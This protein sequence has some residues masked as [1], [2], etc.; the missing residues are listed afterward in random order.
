MMDK[1]GLATG[2]TD[3]GFH[4]LFNVVAGNEIETENGEIKQE[5]MKLYFLIGN[6]I[7]PFGTPSRVTAENLYYMVHALWP[8][9]I[10]DVRGFDF[11]LDN[12]EK[13]LN[14]DKDDVLFKPRNKLTPSSGLLNFVLYQEYRL[15]SKE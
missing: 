6:K 4:Y 2:I 15:K 14:W 8:F 10:H 11:Q 7:G 5:Q 12:G 3:G 13:A 1:I 9:K